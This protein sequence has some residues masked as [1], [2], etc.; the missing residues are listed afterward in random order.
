MSTQPEA[1]FKRTLIEGFETAFG[2]KAEDAVWSYVKGSKDGLPDL[3]FSF[4]GLSM[5]VEA[6]V[7][8]NDLEKSQAYF[9]PR[10]ARAG[11]NVWVASA[12]S[13]DKRVNRVATFSQMGQSGEK[14]RYLTVQGWKTTFRTPEF[15]KLFKEQP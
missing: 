3:Y 7:G 13:V 15:W 12:N 14:T 2:S 6:K 5:W 11:S 8:G 1:K 10:M 9:L 4:L